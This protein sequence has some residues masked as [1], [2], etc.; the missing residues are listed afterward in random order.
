MLEVAM[1]PEEAIH[2]SECVQTLFEIQ[3]QSAVVIGRNARIRWWISVEMQYGCHLDLVWT[4]THQRKID[5]FLYEA[6]EGA[7]QLWYT[8]ESPPV[9]ANK[10]GLRQITSQDGDTTIQYFDAAM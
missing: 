10:L 4:G 3:Q 7:A 8:L 9:V 2:A 6:D 5:D 1:I